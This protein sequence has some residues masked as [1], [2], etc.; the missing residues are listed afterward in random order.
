L[1]KAGASKNRFYLRQKAFR[2]PAPVAAVA[3]AVATVE[4]QGDNLIKKI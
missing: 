3:P 4:K 2:R 1:E